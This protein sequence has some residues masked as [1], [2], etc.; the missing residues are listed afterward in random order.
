MNMDKDEPEYLLCKRWREDVLELT[1]EQL[2][3]LTGYSAGVIKD[4][5]RPDKKIDE[6]ARKRYRLAVA[7]ASFGIE[8]NWVET[9]FKPFVPITISIR[10]DDP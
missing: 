2:S 5:E 1:R 6:K 4:Y 9:T 10:R 3:T 7:A 8:F